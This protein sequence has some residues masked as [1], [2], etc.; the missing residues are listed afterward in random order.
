MD[1][2]YLG[3]YTDGSNTGIHSLSVDPNL[4]QPLKVDRLIEEADPC[5][6]C[7]SA[8]Q[9]SL[10]TLSNA[11]S[12]PGVS[13]YRWTGEGYQLADRLAFL[14]EPACYVSL[15]T[16]EHY[17]LCA[18]YRQAS[19]ILIKV[20]AN[21]KLE[22]TDIVQRTGSGPHPNQDRP[23][24]HY[25]KQYRDSPYFLACDLG[26]DEVL[27]YRIQ[28]DKLQLVDTLAI[29]AGSGPRHLVAHPTLPYVYVLSELSYT[30]DV[31][32]IDETTSQLTALGRYQTLDQAPQ[33]FNSSAAIRISSDGRFLYCSNRGENT[34][35]VFA[36]SRD[37]R[38]L[39][40]IQVIAS[41]GD[42]PRDFN[43]SPDE[44]YLLVAHQNDGHLRLFDRDPET[45]LLTAKDFDYQLDQVVC[46]QSIS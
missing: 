14:E 8:D 10:F 46:V 20:Q 37:G 44:S 16:D 11:G 4:D 1:Q 23:H 13:Y 7:L 31:V 22:L 26:T 25:F 45:G 39:D 18:S 17:V 34:L 38:S 27:S 28:E 41:Q 33:A 40:R 6:F 19:L 32:Q 36:L 5:Y 35:T 21:G 30:V 12:E 24:C 43:L 15:S 3:A 42:F 29:P 9:K 2:F